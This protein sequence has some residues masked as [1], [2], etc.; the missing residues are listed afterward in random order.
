MEQKQGTRGGYRPGAGRKAE[1]LSVMQI[2]KMLAKAEQMALDTGKDVDD[3]LLGI[4][5]DSS[6]ETNQ[7]QAIKI[8]KQYTMAAPS[9]GGEADRELGPAVYLPEH[10]PNL[11]MIEG[12]KP[13]A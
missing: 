13:A 9:E 6:S 3:I 2:Q 12:G 11:E 7:L 5:K 1:T 4:I 10:R 8:W